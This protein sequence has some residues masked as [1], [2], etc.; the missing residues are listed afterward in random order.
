MKIIPGVLAALVLSLA[1]AVQGNEL[2]STNVPESAKATVEQ[3]AGALCS[4]DAS[5]DL[6]YKVTLG[7][8]IYN[9]DEEGTGMMANVATTV[10]AESLV[11][12]KQSRSKQKGAVV[13]LKGKY[14][15]MSGY[16]FGIEEMKEGNRSA[17]RQE[18]GV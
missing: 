2:I 14:G 3:I 17:L 1:S 18:L 9:C 13:A 4:V 10:V 5:P 7:D 8:T 16:H 6:H 12:K 11:L 15:P